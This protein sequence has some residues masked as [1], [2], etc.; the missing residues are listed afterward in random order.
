MHATPVKRSQTESEACSLTQ[1]WKLTEL[2]GFRISHSRT[3]RFAVEYSPIM[4]EFSVNP[5]RVDPYKNFKFR[6]KWDG[7][8][9]AGISKISGL[10]R[11]TEERRLERDQ[12]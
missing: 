7:R 5:T 9:V 3:L 2:A 6:V 8:Y 11:T 4:A 12:W 1:L 10:R